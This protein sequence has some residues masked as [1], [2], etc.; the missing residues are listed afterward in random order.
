MKL[1]GVCFLYVQ[2][3]EVCLNTN[4]GW[5]YLGLDIHLPEKSIRI[6]D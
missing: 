4:D 6:V 1:L 3:E 5:E 2:K